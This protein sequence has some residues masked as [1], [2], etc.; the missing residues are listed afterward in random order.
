MSVSSEVPNFEKLTEAQGHRLS[1]FIVSTCLEPLMKHKAR[2]ADL[3]SQNEVV[4]RE[5]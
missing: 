3:T 2:V 5:D 1:A 4:N